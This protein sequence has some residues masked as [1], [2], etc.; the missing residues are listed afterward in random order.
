MLVPASAKVPVLHTCLS[1]FIST[2]VLPRPSD[3]TTPNAKKVFCLLLSH[4]TFLYVPLPPN[5]PF[6]PTSFF[7]S[8]FSKCLLRS[9]SHPLQCLGEDRL[10]EALKSHESK[11][12]SETALSA[13]TI[14]CICRDAWPG[15]L[16]DSGLSSILRGGAEMS[17]SLVG[18]FRRY[19]P[20]PYLISNY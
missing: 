6:H 19:Q 16:E 5:T 11:P 7:S 1:P 2:S 9:Y 8:H 12:G 3:K 4:F 10:T 13:L 14:S 17:L 18:T 20:L 15:H